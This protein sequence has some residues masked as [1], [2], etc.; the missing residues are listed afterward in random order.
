MVV[1]QNIVPIIS[2]NAVL[3]LGGKNHQVEIEVHI[4]G[5]FSTLVA[6]KIELK[7]PLIMEYKDKVEIPVH[8]TENIYLILNVERKTYK[9]GHSLDPISELLKMQESSDCTFVLIACCPGNS[10]SEAE[11]TSKY[12]SYHIKNKWYNFTDEVI[13]GLI[14][15]FTKRRCQTAGEV[16]QEEV[17]GPQE[18]SLSE[19]EI[20]ENEVPSL[21][22]IVVK[23][24]KYFLKKSI[25]SG[26]KMEGE[27]NF[28]HKKSAYITETE[29]TP[30]VVFPTSKK[31]IFKKIEE[32]ESEEEN[33]SK[34]K[35]SI[36]STESDEG[37][38]ENKSEGEEES[39]SE[40]EMPAV[41][42]SRSRKHLLKSMIPT[43]LSKLSK[44]VNPTKEILSS[45]ILEERNTLLSKTRL[46]ETSWSNNFWEKNYNKSVYHYREFFRNNLEEKIHLDCGEFKFFEMEYSLMKCKNDK[47]EVWHENAKR[48]TLN[49]DFK[50][51]DILSN[52]FIINKGREG[53]DKGIWNL[54]T[55]KLVR[56]INVYA[57][58]P[59]FILDNKYL[60][61]L[62]NPSKYVL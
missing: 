35:D 22:S 13:S 55:G 33:K 30:V 23:K 7:G 40:E 26:G 31:L 3:I 29:R 57:W 47:L 51:I 62:G 60:V 53:S 1:G 34:G 4:K 59:C 6:N 15:D 43:K 10:T 49:G 48:H 41:F 61:Q 58:A 42:L 32:S 5:E 52:V 54:E 18:N 14:Y 25:H 36:S 37:E 9:L 24:P 56:K 12:N 27:E 46:R 20:S 50:H 39:E 2:T 28:I 45:V 17:Q 16:V 21:Q 44:I 11:L 38:E 8:G 19:E